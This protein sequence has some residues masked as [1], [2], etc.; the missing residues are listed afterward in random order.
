[1]RQ[2][3][4][5]AV[6]VV[7][8]TA[9]VLIL[10]ESGTGKEVLARAIHRSSGRRGKPFL[11][12]NCAAMPETLVE[13]ELFGHEKGAFTGATS[14]KKGRF[15]L[16]DGGTLFLDEIADMSLPLQAKLLRV[17]QEGEIR[18]VGST[19]SSIVDVRIISATNKTLEKEVE[20][21]RFRQDLYYRLHVFPIR[22]PP[23]RERREDIPLLARHFMAKYA[24]ELNK[25]VAGF[26]QEALDQVVTYAW[27]GNVRELENEAQRLVITCDEGGFIQ[28]EHLSARIRQVEG[29]VD[30]IGPRQGTLK[31]M[32]E[33][34]E[35]YL[36]RE[37]LREHEGNKTRTA[38]T[39]GI[40][41][42]G[43]HKKLSKFGMG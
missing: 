34:V 29:I 23:L 3:K 41:R 40:T 18:P 43:L 9:S 31:E 11:V 39:L 36:L 28:P 20:E 1:M 10:G 37:A 19:R 22:L 25:D 7:P 13:S 35:R 8:S 21:G 42:E 5:L 2:V 26:S 27:P 6:K 14:E 15:E 30:R 16:A 17:L 38:V 32:M 12:I 33:Q 4:E 24:A